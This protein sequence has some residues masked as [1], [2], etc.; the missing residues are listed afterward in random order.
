MLALQPALSNKPRFV[1]EE[2]LVVWLVLDA[3]LLVHLLLRVGA[4]SL[5]CLQQSRRAFRVCKSTV[6]PCD[7]LILQ[8][9]S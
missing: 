7:F 1:A 2:C 5:P 9:A 8:N 4:V 3:K 6:R